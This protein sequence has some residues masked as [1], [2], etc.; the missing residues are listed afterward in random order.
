MDLQSMPRYRR[1]VL[2]L[3]VALGALIGLPG[4]ARADEGDDDNGPGLVFTETNTAPNFVSVFQ[5][6]ADGTLVASGQVATGGNGRPAGNPPLDLP[7]LQTTGEVHLGGNGDE[8]RCLFVVNAG[9]NTVSSFVVRSQGARLAD[10]QPSNGSRPIS[11]TSTQRGPNN[12]VLYVLNSDL[13]GTSIFNSSSGSAS[14]QGFY[15]SERCRMT[16]IQ[17][18]FHLTSSQASTP[19]AIAFNRRGN[20]LSVVEPVTPANGDIDVFPVDS[21]GVAGNP[22]VSPSAGINPYGEAWDGRGH[23]TVTNWTVA[24]PPDGTVSSYRLTSDYHLVPINTVPAPGHPCWNVITNDDRFLYTT[25]PAGLVIG[26]PQ[27]LGYAIGRD[28]TLTPTGS[29][30]TTP[31]NAVDEALS[32]DSRFLYVLNDGLL[33]FTP[34]SAVS[35]FSV[36]R[37]SGQLTPIGQVNLPGNGTSGLAAW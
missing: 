1:S 37:R 2:V 4:L 22:V 14:I 17:G 7:Y 35:E 11:L 5:R 27:I 18:S 34:Q 10:Q 21:R 32:R 31:F 6:N 30:Q 16:P 19:T 29:G 24:S 23:L 8:R 9:S 28:G 12:L 25:Q 26:T 3:A 36:D 13:N 33:P 15:V 20:A